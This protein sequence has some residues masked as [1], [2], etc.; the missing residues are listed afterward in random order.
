MRYLFINIIFAVSYFFCLSAQAKITIA[1]VAPMVDEY[2]RQG[3]ELTLGVERAIDEINQQGGILKQ[4]ISLL[5]IDDQCND[6]IAIST[7]Q[8][9]T[10]LHNKKISLVIGPYCA[11]AF[12]R[13]ADIYAAARIFQIIPTAVDYKQA[14]TIKKGLV[15]MLGYTDQAAKDFFAF[16]NANFAGDRIALVSNLDDDESI[17]AAKAIEHEF[18]IHGKSALL[19]SYNYQMTQK[20][21]SDLAEKILQ[22]GEQLAFLLGSP[23]NIRKMALALR[24]NSKD[25][26]I[27]INKT[28]TGDKFFAALD[29]L[30]EGIYLME[31]KGTVDDPEFVE[32]LVRL[33]L[34]GFE[35]EGLSLY[36]YSAVKLWQNL[37]QKA[38]SFDYDKLS[39]ALNNKTIRTELGY[40]MFHNGAPK[41]SES[42]Y[43]Y[44]YHINDLTNG[45]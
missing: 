39:A 17:S 28:Q 4:K 42:Y 3:A 16:Y 43:I 21:Y 24:N 26:V 30:A 37:V 40:K 36:G 5:K 19:Y 23:A 11:N 15:K 8:M 38:Q 18:K 31:L 12:E 32:T 35:A 20:N 10:I 7:A 45:D 9:L 6:S 41:V 1:L 13:V 34:N 2:Q 25:F 33:R 44:R 27:F 29:D 22:N 14:K